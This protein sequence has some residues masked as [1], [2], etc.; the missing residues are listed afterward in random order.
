MNRT[1]TGYTADDVSELKNTNKNAYK[2]LKDLYNNAL[3]FQIK[4]NGSIGFKYLVKECQDYKNSYK[5]I[6]EFSKENIVKKDEWN[7]I[8]IRLKRMSEFKMKILIYVNNFLIYV[9]SE[10]DVI[11]LRPLSDIE[12]KQETVPF[13]IS[14]GGGTQGLIETIYPDYMNL[15]KYVLPLEKHFAG[16]FLGYIKD[17]KVFIGKNGIRRN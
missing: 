4:D 6:E 7:N 16:S 8:H 1:C 2:I 10:L 3:G 15:P 13:N 9:S 12:E 17:F 11:N 5:I 14:L